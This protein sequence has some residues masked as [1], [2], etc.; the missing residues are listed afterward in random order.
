LKKCGLS[1][2]DK[3]ITAIVLPPPQLIPKSSTNGS[4]SADDIVSSA[5]GTVVVTI[6]KGKFSRIKLKAGWLAALLEP[7]SNEAY[8]PKALDSPKRLLAP[9]E[10]MSGQSRHPSPPTVPDKLTKEPDTNYLLD[11]NLTAFASVMVS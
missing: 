4:A 11:V 6:K 2:H 9:K 10:T 7:R 5:N 8:R 3:K 1:L